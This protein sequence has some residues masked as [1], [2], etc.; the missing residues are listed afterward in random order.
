MNDIL[1]QEDA[2][3]SETNFSGVSVF[4]ASSCVVKPTDVGTFSTEHDSYF[5]LGARSGNVVIGLR[6]HGLCTQRRWFTEKIIELT[7]TVD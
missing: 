3:C 7:S 1:T 2:E 5:F 4:S 6:A